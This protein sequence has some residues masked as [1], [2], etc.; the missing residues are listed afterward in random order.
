MRVSYLLIGMAVIAMLVLFNYAHAAVLNG[1]NMS[2]AINT[3]EA[4]VNRV[5]QS[6]YLI[7]YPNLTASYHDISLATNYS[8]SNA[9]YA[10]SLLSIA[11]ENAQAQQLK[12]Y[13]YKTYSL[14]VL[15]L[16]ALILLCVLYSLMKLRKTAETRRKS[17]KKS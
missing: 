6:G 1:T 8:K 13:Q 14:Y 10:Y 3:T 7:F 16:S 2:Y 15:I 5:N 11:R 9:S 4:F 17:I 12:I